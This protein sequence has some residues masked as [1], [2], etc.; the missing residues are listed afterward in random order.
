MQEFYVKDRKIGG[1]APVFII[2]EMSA[3][4]LQ[5]YE[6]AIKIIKEAA[7]AGADAIKLQTY[8]PDTMTLNSNKKYFQITQGTIWD[9]TTL[10]ELYKKAYTPWDWQPKLKEIAEEL[11][12]IFFSTP[13]DKTSVDFLEEM[14][15]DLYKIASFEI[16][17]IPLIKEIAKKG[18]PIIFSNG[19]AE[20]SDIELAIKTMK[21]ENNE[22]I[23]MLKC[24]SA[25]PTP[26]EES[27]LLTISNIRDTFNIVA[28]LSDHSQG[29][30][31]PITS[32]ALGAKII[33]KHMCLDRN[34]GGPDAK[35]S[36]EPEE[37][38]L[39]VKS[40]REAEKAL[41]KVSYELTEKQLK[42]KEH[43]RSI[44]I[45]KD[46]KK[47]EKITEDN[48]IITRPAF[49]LHPKYYEE[50]LNKTAKVDIEEGEPLKWSYIH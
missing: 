4:H 24:T 28:G 40:V 47:G 39:M 13:F 16:N 44:F 32:V 14:N 49:G 5:D 10:Y 29:I 30:T 9:G 19:I 41:G 1:N 25:Y 45:S 26:I 48:I 27:N 11:G 42:S 6:K 15:V 31:V 36:L 43:S 23:A 2:A 17:D 12:L 38:K 50:I 7:N 18:K 35:F 3:N 33:E 46:I 8:T 21:Y 34:L 20:L 37:F 22:K